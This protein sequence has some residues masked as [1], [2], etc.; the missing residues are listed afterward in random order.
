MPN[1][2]LPLL[3]QALPSRA[4]EHLGL[5]TGP[6][7]PHSEW[8]RGYWRILAELCLQVGRSAVSVDRSRAHKVKKATQT[9]VHTTLG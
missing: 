8:D 4:R 2:I 3:D 7:S 9:K 1:K 6:E 5:A